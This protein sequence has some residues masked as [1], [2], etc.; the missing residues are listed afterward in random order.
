[1]GIRRADERLKSAAAPESGGQVL[2]GRAVHPHG[3]PQRRVMLGG[4][5]EASDN[6][7]IVG[8]LVHRERVMNPPR[9]GQVFFPEIALTRELYADDRLAVVARPGECV[10]VE[11]PRCSR[12]DF[13]RDLDREFDVLPSAVQQGEGVAERIEEVPESFRLSR[14][15]AAFHLHALVPGHGRD[16]DRAA[17][18]GLTGL[19]RHVREVALGNRLGS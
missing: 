18:T 14:G 17:E 1:M 5:K 4:F 7:F 12:P 6:A 2:D 9:Q 15:V 3:V 10:E 8:P 11:Y 19:L 13:V 16:R